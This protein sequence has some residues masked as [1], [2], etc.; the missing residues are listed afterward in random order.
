MGNGA[1]FQDRS[2]EAPAE[3]EQ[4]SQIDLVSDRDSYSQVQQALRG[5]V[6]ASQFL[7]V[8][9]LIDPKDAEQLDEPQSRISGAS[10]LV[11]PPGTD[12]Q[13]SFAELPSPT[14]KT[15]SAPLSEMMTADDD[16]KPAD[17]DPL[18]AK[19][20]KGEDDPK[21][22]KGKKVSSGVIDLEA[23]MKKHGLRDL[24]EQ[25]NDTVAVGTK[26]FSLQ[27]YKGKAEYFEDATGSWRSPDKSGV[28][29][30]RSDNPK[31]KWRGTIEIG[32]NKEWI[33]KD[34]DNGITDTYQKDGTQ[35][36]T[37]RDAQV[38]S[39]KDG[40]LQAFTGPDGK[41]WLTEDGKEWF[42]PGSDDTKK[43][44]P[45]IDDKGKFRFVPL[46]ETE[47]KEPKEKEPE[48]ERPATG[49][50]AEEIQKLKE[51]I[52]EKFGVKVATPGESKLVYGHR[53]KAVEPSL[54][55]MTVLR[56]T[57]SKSKHLDTTGLKVWFMD[58]SSPVPK[59]LNNTGAVYSSAS[60]I[61]KP[62]L[63][64]LPMAREQAKGWNGTEGYLL[65]EL[66]HHDQSTRG[67]FDLGKKEAPASK[68]L[69]E[70]M[71]WVKTAEHGTV[72]LD[73][74]SRQ[75]KYDPADGGKWQFVKG[76][77]PD[78]GKVTLTSGEMR[79]QALVR[80]A[81]KYFTHPCEMHAEAM[82]LYQF[83]PERLRKDSPG[84]YKTIKADYEAAVKAV[85]RKK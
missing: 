43:G 34:L 48:A 23:I 82:A 50:K 69:V 14:R 85:S 65:H 20:S 8:M 36:R 32:Q 57:L 29:W 16:P 2:V 21:P 7:P 22:E 58:K 70:D 41:S 75:W 27:K 84:L 18:P 55:E 1:E 53:F 59:D 45:S 67:L 46:K 13:V 30:E 49:D 9:M 4:P 33:K 73:K 42:R 66:S 5:S 80:P 12:S 72:L 15:G 83:S 61:T 11:P 79:E 6:G 25:E 31:V 26:K 37:T 35:R 28:N 64:L 74:E 62:D 38:V 51:E 52:Q 3:R 56:D 40:K 60:S 19:E 76:E 10:D 44:T 47:K 78:D 17:D 54:E 39:D 63:V 68:Q 77:R 71:G 24:S 81:T